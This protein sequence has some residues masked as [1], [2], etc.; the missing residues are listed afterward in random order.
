[1][2]DTELDVRQLRKPGKH[3]TIFATLARDS[4]RKA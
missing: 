4:P 2:A 3:P 1:M